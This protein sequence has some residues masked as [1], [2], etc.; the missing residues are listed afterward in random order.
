MTISRRVFVRNSALALVS[1]GMD[2]LFLPRAI[3][4]PYR[5]LPSLTVLDRPVL[6]CLFQ[7][8]AVDGLNMI[9]PHGEAAYYQE[10]PRIAIPASDVVDLDGHFGLHPSLAPLKSLWDNKSLAAIHAIGSPDGT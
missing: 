3:Y 9:V 2:P 6:V 5:P 1:F 10:R 8:G 4:Y 7:R